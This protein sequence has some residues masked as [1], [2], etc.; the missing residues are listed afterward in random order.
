MDRSPIAVCMVSGAEA[1]RIRRALESVAGWTSEI[2]VV[3]N[4]EAQDG[5]DGIAAGFG[6][7]VFREPWKGFAAQKNSAADK[8]SPPWLLGLDADEAVSAGLRDEIVEAVASETR[9]PRCAAFG[10]PRC[11]FFEGKWIRHGDWY[12]D[13]K[14]LLWRRGQARWAGVEPHAKLDVS[15]PVGWLRHD[16]LHYSMESL[17]HFVRKSM[18]YSDVFVREA[19]SAK[20]HVTALDLWGRPLWRFVRGYILRLGF[21]DGWQ[22]YC[23]ARMAAFQTFLRYAKLRESVAHP[24]PSRMVPSPPK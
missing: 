17:D 19:A 10:F 8:A 11:T 3:L 1:H 6:A 23:I 22:G 15:G 14:V 13:R 20:R 2:V 9:A 12:P 7:T 18:A 5:T 21:L 4:E 16:L 24:A